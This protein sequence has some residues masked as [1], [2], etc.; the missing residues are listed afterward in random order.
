LG[1]IANELISNAL[2]HAWAGSPEEGPVT[3]KLKIGFSRFKDRLAN[4]HC[5]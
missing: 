2:T 3:K 5:R 4:D 1:I